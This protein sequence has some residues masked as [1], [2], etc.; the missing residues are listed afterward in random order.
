[1]KQQD[2]QSEYKA[3]NFIKT[4]GGFGNRCGEREKTAFTSQI[5]SVERV[6]EV[7]EE[8][9]KASEDKKSEI[10]RGMDDSGY[11]KFSDSGFLNC[12]DEEYQT[13]IR[14]IKRRYREKR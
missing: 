13:Q 6:N 11:C 7:K 3:R 8:R 5:K 4:Y 14:S 1:M 12:L 10:R 9:Q 2:N